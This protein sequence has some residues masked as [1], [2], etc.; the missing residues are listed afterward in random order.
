MYFKTCHILWTFFVVVRFFW[1]ILHLPIERIGIHPDCGKQK[2]VF[3][4]FEVIDLLW[5]KPDYYIHKSQFLW[6]SCRFRK[7]LKAIFQMK[8]VPRVYACF[9]FIFKKLIIFKTHVS[10]TCVNSS[11]PRR[12]IITFHEVKNGVEVIFFIQKLNMKLRNFLL[13]M[14]F[15]IGVVIFKFFWSVFS[16][17]CKFFSCYSSSWWK[18]MNAG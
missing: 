18:Y 8:K 3:L 13:V 5:G 6:L 9:L 4:G 12:M 2:R 15:E 10:E 11:V 17:F 1:W 16:L 7:I 14:L